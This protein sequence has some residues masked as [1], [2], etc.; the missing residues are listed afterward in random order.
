MT[1]LRFTRG[2]PA[3]LLLPRQ[4]CARLAGNDCQV[5]NALFVILTVCE[6]FGMMRAFVLSV[7]EGSEFTL[8]CGFARR[9]KRFLLTPR[10]SIR[11]AYVL[12]DSEH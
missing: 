2:A 1:A 5:Q 12:S 6:F 4:F 7:S 10:D 9:A 8:E 3:L 11:V